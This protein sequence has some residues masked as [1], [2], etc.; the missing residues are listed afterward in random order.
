MP[1]LYL[2]PSTQEGNPVVIGNSEEYYMNL[3]ADAMEP[4][5]TSNGILFR[6]NDRNASLGQAIRESNAGNYDLHLALHSNA[7]PPANAGNVQGADF[8]YYTTSAPSREAATV[9][10]ENYKRIYPYPEKSR[11]LPTT[12]LAELRQTRAPAVL[13]EL[14]YHDN[15]AEATWIRD[16]IEGI[17]RNL[18]EGLTEYFSIPFV[19]AQAPAVG[20]VRVTSGGLNL[21]DRPN[22]QASVLRVIPN[23][24]TVTVN[25]RWDNWYVVTYDGVTGYANAAYIAV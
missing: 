19:E 17:A 21:R 10:A 9:L 12:S 3:I 6:R 8:Y 4:Y 1:T 15:V 22:T 18:V 16:N 7:A 25:G 2:S 14:A 11:P 23:G 5:L 20:T 24:A 13:A